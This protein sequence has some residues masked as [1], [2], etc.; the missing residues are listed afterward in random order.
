MKTLYIIGNGFDL[1]HK[2]PTKPKDFHEYIIN[3][4]ND[5]KNDL[6]K[7]FNFTTEKGKWKNFEE[8]LGTFNWNSFFSN[9]S[10][11]DVHR[12][13]FKTSMT[14]SL[15]DDLNELS[16]YLIDQIRES[17]AS[18]L[19]D[20][21]LNATEPNISFETDSFF[22]T[23]NYTLL[24]EI[25]YKI[26]SKNILHIHGDIENEWE[27]IIFGHNKF[28][29]EDPEL[30]ENGDSNRTLLSEAEAAA[31]YP[32]YAFHKPVK[33]TIEKNRQLFENLYTV[34][35][36]IVLG[37]SLNLIDLPY[38][39]EIHRNANN[40]TWEVSFHDP[41]DEEKHLETL[42]G[43]GVNKNCIKLFKMPPML[44]HVCNSCP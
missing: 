35:K 16:E 34:T 22:I 25:I 17:F 5:L 42:K 26:R 13:N 32:F 43:I 15:E 12:E 27:S 29:E 3:N 18:W 14:Y 39:E 20:I 11:I 41:E 28:M 19:D 31:K 6:K 40:A 4:Q 30:D 10:N 8:D 7:Y 37:H 1:H 33:G 44:A 9:N 23:F 2:L 24:L 38:F 21:D 36:I